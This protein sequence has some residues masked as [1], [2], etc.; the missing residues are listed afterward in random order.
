VSIPDRDDGVPGRARR[1]LVWLAMVAATSCAAPSSPTSN[2]PIVGV[3]TLDFVIGDPALWPRIGNQAQH[4]VVDPYSHE[5][6]WTKYANP[7]MFECWRWDDEW[8]YHRVDHG[9]DG[10]TGESYEF[11][12]GRW[13]PRRLA[14]SWSL[15]VT[16]N[17]I[18]WFDPTCQPIF[19]KSGD[20][21]YEMAAW[22][23]PARYLGADLGT[24]EIL[25]L[26]YRPAAGRPVNYVERFYFA[27][28]AGWYAWE[29]PRGIVRFDRFGGPRAS[30]GSSCGESTSLAGSLEDVR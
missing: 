4:Q 19:S 8:I 28:G 12:D 3:D 20:Y 24:R 6:C 13:L 2:R 16:R 21:S 23:E 1:L 26:E 14:G 10:A 30:R 18:Q 7:R 15:D 27:R 22:L 9:I 5:V 25:V 29:H 17:R 11:T